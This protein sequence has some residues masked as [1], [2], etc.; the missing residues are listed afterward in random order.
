MNLD[1]GC[2]KPREKYEGSASQ[3]AVGN[4]CIP[5]STPGLPILLE[6]QDKWNHNYCRNSPGI[7]DIPICFIN[8]SDY[9]ECEIPM[10]DPIPDPGKEFVL[11]DI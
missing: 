2:L 6:D 1:I 5:W 8:E 7:D 9:D 11:F 4:A 10:C 3:T